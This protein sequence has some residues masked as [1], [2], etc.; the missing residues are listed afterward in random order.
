MRVVT[1]AAMQQVKEPH[2]RLP[3]DEERGATVRLGS[4]QESPPA[5]HASTLHSC[6]LWARE[7]QDEVPASL[8][9]YSVTR[10]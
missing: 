5:G 4:G 8:R 6:L 2:A 1:E 9:L 10:T 3:R 7:D